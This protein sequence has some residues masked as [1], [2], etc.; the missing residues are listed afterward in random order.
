[1]PIAAAVANA[2]Y[3]ATGQ[4]IRELP[5]QRQLAAAAGVS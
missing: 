1:V 2:I 3:D 4:R 5:L